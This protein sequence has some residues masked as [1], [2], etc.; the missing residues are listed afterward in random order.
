MEPSFV[1][2]ITVMYWTFF[3][4]QDGFAAPCSFVNGSTNVDIDLAHQ[5]EI[6]Y[7]VADTVLSNAPTIRSDWLL[8]LVLPLQP[9]LLCNL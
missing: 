5:Q 9:F 6:H 7:K 2:A 8:Y 4:M 3:A 1:N